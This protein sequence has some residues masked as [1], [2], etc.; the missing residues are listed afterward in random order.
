MGANFLRFQLV[1][2]GTGGA[3]VMSPLGQSAAQVVRP[4]LLRGITNQGLLSRIRDGWRRLAISRFGPTL[5]ERNQQAA[6]DRAAG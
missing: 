4:I 1:G 6:A 3:G 5:P 2:Q